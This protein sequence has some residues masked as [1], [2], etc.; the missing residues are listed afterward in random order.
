MVG[1]LIDETQTAEQSSRRQ[2]VNINP[3]EVPKKSGK[4]T[5]PS[6]S[7]D[8]ENAEETSKEENESDSSFAEKVVDSVLAEEDAIEVE[9]AALNPS[10]F[11]QTL[12][13]LITFCVVFNW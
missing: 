8:Q 3:P 9:C 6:G 1:P 2:A 5:T 12:L 11:L 13:S 4:S 10:S 7:D